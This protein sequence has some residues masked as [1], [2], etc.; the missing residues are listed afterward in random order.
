MYHPLLAADV[1]P[2][3]YDGMTPGTPGTP[4]S[5]SLADV[6]ILIVN[7]IHIVTWWAGALSVIFIVVGGIFY[8]ISAGNPA[9]IKRAKEIITAAIVGLMIS[10]LAFTIVSFIAGRF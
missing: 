9:N 1:F 8:V 7:I 2:G 10:G 4:G 5:L 3:L 6:P